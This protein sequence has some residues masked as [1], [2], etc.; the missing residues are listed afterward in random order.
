M[1]G[2]LVYLLLS[3]LFLVRVLRYHRWITRSSSA[4][5][6]GWWAWIP[7]I[8]L[9]SLLIGQAR[10]QLFGFFNE[11][12]LRVQRGFDARDDIIGYR[13]YR[14]SILDA[15]HL[16]LACEEDSDNRR[17]RKYPS[18]SASVHLTGYHHPV[19][20]STGM[21]LVLDAPLMGRAITTPADFFRLLANG[22]VHRNLYGNP[23]V[24]TVYKELQEAASDALS[25]RSGAVVVLNPQNGSM[26]AMVSSPGFD[27][28]TLNEQMFHQ[29]R[30]R[31]D[32]PFLNRAM[33]GLYPPGSTFKTLIGLSALEKKI[34]PAYTCTVQGFDCGPYDRPVRDYQ[35]YVM[36]NQE[37]QFKGHGD[38]DLNTAMVKSCNGYFAHLGVALGS[39]TVWEIAHRMGM[40]EPI[41]PVGPGLTAMAGVL[42]RVPLPKAR[43][44]RFGIG[45]DEL[46]VTPF[47]LAL[48]AGALGNDGIMYRPRFVTG[49]KPDRWKQITS[50]RICTQIARSMIRV[51]EEGT[52]RD[53]RVSGV[54]IGGKTGTSENAASESHALFIGFAPW[55]MPT[56]ALAVV[57]EQ[58][59]SGGTVAAPIAARIFQTARDM[60]LLKEEAA[61]GTQE[62]IPHHS[63]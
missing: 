40:D 53:A 6:T 60:D 27:P 13:F 24:L 3:I 61:D 49:T 5:K 57:V 48:I 11:G 55:P 21:E 59:G 8:L 2:T 15:R 1:I 46:L 29:L 30:N 62:T 23:V 28:D 10:W 25:G 16:P 39:D 43:L 58:G 34:Q 42:P 41:T 35:Y 7:G 17:I 4:K 47:H 31:E 63:P 14:G 18:G 9:V 56:V 51:V 36:K 50:A 12:F 44:A 26:L 54:V 38:I 32:S 45:Q 20:G 52:G 22:F 37:R 33:Q 19:Y